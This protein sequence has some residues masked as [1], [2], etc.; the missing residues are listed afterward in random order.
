MILVDVFVP[1]ID[2]KY[3][4]RLN[5][6]VPVQFHPALRPVPSAPV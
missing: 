4:F 2:K 5:E 6:E 3:D 1:S